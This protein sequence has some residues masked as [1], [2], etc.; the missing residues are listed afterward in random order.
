M[1]G[2]LTL[3]TVHK[4][5]PYFPQG[6]AQTKLDES[7]GEMTYV[8]EKARVHRPGHLNHSLTLGLIYMVHICVWGKVARTSLTISSEDQSRR[9]RLTKFDWW[10]SCNC[11]DDYCPCLWNFV[12]RAGLC[13]NPSPTCQA[14]R[15]VTSGE[16]GKDGYKKGNF[17]VLKRTWLGTETHLLNQST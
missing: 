16:S 15:W 1:S 10:I 11:G 4:L 13:R 6:D 14:H 7:L 2:L 3:M 8:A 12:N 17:K 5:R 9:D